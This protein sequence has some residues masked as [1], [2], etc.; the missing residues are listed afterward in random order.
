VVDR[1]ACAIATER[2][3]LRVQMISDARAPISVF[4]VG[5]GAVAAGRVIRFEKI[6]AI[7]P[8]PRGEYDGLIWPHCDSLKWPHLVA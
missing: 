1:S 2:R 8:L 5:A 6:V 4:E 7:R 3:D